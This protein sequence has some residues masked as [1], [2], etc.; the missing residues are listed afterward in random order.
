M[1]EFSRNENI[2]PKILYKY[3]TY[4]D[5]VSDFLSGKSIK[6]ASRLDFND[7]FDCR[8][9]YTDGEL[10][11]NIANY[12]V[13][14]K[15]RNIS[16]ERRA[17]EIEVLKII[18]NDR[19]IKFERSIGE[20]LDKVGV[21]CVTE[22]WDNFLMW[23]HYA[24]HHR[25][26]CVGFKTDVDV[27]KTASKV[28]YQCEKPIVAMPLPFSKMDELYMLTYLTKA[29]FWDIEGEWRIIKK[30]F[31]EA[32]RQREK[33]F[34]IERKKGQDAKLYYDHHGAGFYEFCNSAIQDITLGAKIDPITES[35][36]RGFVQALN[37]DIVIYKAKL[38]DYE[39]SVLR[40]TAG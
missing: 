9:A 13:R 19:L 34:A 17:K 36:I 18:S 23:S 37:L 30:P 10:K 12:E 25:G 26:V 5:W 1:F 14:A 4:G 20:V 27:F 3:F 24:D 8:P 29:R 2:L 7:P 28:N 21:L 6:F 38:A 22:K 31:S 39:Y 35:R 15:I 32:D 40:E 16:Q 33:K 11:T